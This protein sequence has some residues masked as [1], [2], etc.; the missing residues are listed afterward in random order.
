M[1]GGD[2]HELQEANW[3]DAVLPCF[4]I[5]F[6]NFFLKLR[7]ATKY[8]GLADNVAEVVGG[9]CTSRIQ[10]IVSTPTSYV[11]RPLV[12]SLNGITQQKRVLLI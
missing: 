10:A 9:F 4:R 8:F 3:K 5:L 12:V 1:P 7:K 6:R 2:C 11:W